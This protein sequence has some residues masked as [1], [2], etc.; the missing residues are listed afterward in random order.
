MTYNPHPTRFS[1]VRAGLSLAVM[2]LAA[3]VGKAGDPAA[4]VTWDES[5]ARHLL[6]RACFGGTPGQ[7]KALAALPLE[8]A[9]DGLLDEA[10]KA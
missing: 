10:A 4:T 2:L 5:A 8:K 6:S 1:P 9:I 3:A 7:A